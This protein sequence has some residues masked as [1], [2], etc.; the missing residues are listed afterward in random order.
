MSKLFGG[1]KQKSTST[2]VTESSSENRAYPFIQGNFG[3]T[4]AA[5]FKQGSTAIGNELA[6]GFD[7]YKGNAGYDFME[8]LGLGRLAGGFAGKGT[9]QSGAAMKA[10]SQFQSGLNNQYY[11]KYFDK[12]L[13]QTQLGINAGQLLAGAGQTSKS[14]GTQQSHS[15]G[16][17]SPGFGGFLGGLASG[18]A[19]SDRRLK[20]NIVEV[21]THPAGL[22]LYEYNFIGDDTRHIGVMADEVASKFPEA[23]GP[24][25]EDGYMTVDYDK[26]MERV[27]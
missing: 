20:E 23:L 14:K 11:D 12:L 15:T 18:V 13:Q 19:K 1:S 6:G 26:L 17:S 5:A 16:K 24:E 3:D 10:L 2:G 25:T 22:S 9:F 27:N 8:K 4:G 7:E 21:G